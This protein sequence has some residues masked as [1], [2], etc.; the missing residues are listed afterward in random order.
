VLTAL[1]GLN[2][3]FLVSGILMWGFIVFLY[4]AIEISGA[5]MATLVSTS[6]PVVSTIGAIFVLHEGLAMQ[7]IIGGVLILWSIYRLVGQ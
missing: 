5:T 3:W 1:A 7:E 4:R 2:G 6:Y